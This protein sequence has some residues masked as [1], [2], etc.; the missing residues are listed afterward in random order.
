MTQGI[1]KITSP[2]GNCYIGSSVNIKRRFIQHKSCL[3]LKKYKNSRFQNAYLKYGQNNLKFEQIFCVFDKS[4]LIEFEQYF[5]DLYDPK[6]NLSKAAQTPA[7]DENVAKKLSD[8]AKNSNK[9]K[10]ARLINQK[11]ASKSVSKPVIRLTDNVRFDSGYAAANFI[12]LEKSKNQIFTAIKNGWMFGGH[13]WK[14]E[15]DNVELKDI[16]NKKSMNEA[17]RKKNAKEKCIQVKS[18]SVKRLLDGE[19]F[20]SA[21]EASRHF[22]SYRTAV[23]DSI[24][25]GVNKLGSRW[26]YV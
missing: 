16:L 2:S 5:I 24:R 15:S 25:L 13:Y 8:S 21:V 10:L 12:G 7:L 18:K 3:R 23:S 9:H 19:I 22:G 11:L 1:Y 14:Y 17:Q 20:P 4:N 6:Y 26:E